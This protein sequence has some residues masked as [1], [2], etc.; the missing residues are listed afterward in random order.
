MAIAAR[1]QTG[2]DSVDGGLDVFEVPTS[3]IHLSFHPSYGA[4]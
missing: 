1:H 3:I 2:S 4:H